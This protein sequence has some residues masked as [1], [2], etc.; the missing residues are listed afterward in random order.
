MLNIAKNQCEE[1][2]LYIVIETNPEFLY[3]ELKL[4]SE[5]LIPFN[6]YFYQNNNK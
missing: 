4:V 3:G 1:M 2:L 5:L 6:I